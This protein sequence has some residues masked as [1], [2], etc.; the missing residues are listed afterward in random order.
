VK[1]RHRS[2]T[3]VVQPAALEDIPIILALCREYG[4]GNVDIRQLKAL[5][6]AVLEGGVHLFIDM[7]TDEVVGC[8]AVYPYKL[9]G[10]ILHELG[11]SVLVPAYRHLG[12]ADVSVAFRSIYSMVNEPGSI[13]VSEIYLDS[14][15]SKAVLER[16]G[17]VE[18]EP[19]QGRRDHAKAVS[20]APVR[21]MELE[22]RAVPR[23]AYLL[24]AMVEGAPILRNGKATFI[25]FADSYWINTEAGKSLLAAL[26][27]GD[28]TPLRPET[29]RDRPPSLKKA[30][31]VRSRR[32][33]PSNRAK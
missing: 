5:V 10:Q 15:K 2:S 18:V 23:L 3:I 16:N 12:I 26:I 19:D 32:R 27:G 20:D 1:D 21:H 4:E 25:R 31:P 22:L 30:V 28:Y 17:Y 13:C 24:L 29:K 11:T 8:G 14:V 33:R 7:E 9:K 6:E